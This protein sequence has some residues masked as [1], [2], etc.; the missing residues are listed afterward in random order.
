MWTGL[1]L[2]GCCTRALA[3]WAQVVRGCEWSAGRCASM[4]KH[5]VDVLR[6]QGCIGAIYCHPWFLLPL[7]LRCVFAAAYGGSMLQ[8]IR[9]WASSASRGSSLAGN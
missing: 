5:V 8:V 1:L 3:R 6:R 9:Q 2:L 7:P 4:I